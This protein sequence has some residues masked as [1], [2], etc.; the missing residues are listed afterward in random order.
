MSYQIVIDESPASDDVRF[1]HRGLVQHNVAR[2]AITDGRDLAVFVRNTAGELLG[3]ICAWT[4]GSCM[5]VEYAWLD[6]RVRGSGIG[7]EIIQKL[8]ETAAA[9]GCTV[10]VV[11]TYSFQAPNFYHKMGYEV[12]AEIDGYPDDVK[13]F[14]LRKEI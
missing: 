5:E 2:S 1:V 7:R 14:I 10:S 6:E 8:E 11:D 13:K 3:G 4:W 12:I 9:R